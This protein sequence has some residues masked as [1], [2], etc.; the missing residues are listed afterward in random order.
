MEN[1]GNS[2]N[3]NNSDSNNNEEKKDKKPKNE[4][5][6]IM[7]AMGL[8]M[9][10]GLSMAFCVVI[11]F[12]IGRFL[13]GLFE[14]VPLFMTIFSFIGMGAAIKVLIDIVKDWE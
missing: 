2:G 8:F 11:G 3:N 6:Q 7:R 14:T 4:K 9:Q 5:Y 13:D 1:N 12:F 10:L